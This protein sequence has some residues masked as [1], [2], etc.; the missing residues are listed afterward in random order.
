MG[1]WTWIAASRRGTSHEKTG[2]RCQDAR[3]CSL[4]GENADVLFAVASDGAGSA[5]HGGQ[6]ASLTCRVLTTHARAHFRTTSSL[7]SDEDIATWVDAVKDNIWAAATQ[8]GLQPRDFAAT[9]VCVIS[10]GNDTVTV[11]VG[12]G[13]AVMKISGHGNWIAASWPN[14]GEYASTTF[15]VT[16]D[17]ELKLR[18]TRLTAE[19]VACAVF[20]DGIERLALDFRN[21]VPFEPFFNAV[22]NPVVASENRGRDAGLSEKLRDFLNSDAV[23]AR[24]DDDKT[25]IIAVN[26]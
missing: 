11:H 10:N 5:S 26:K 24:T 7:P 22:V 23:N 25:L 19:V 21:N 14:H 6:G 8:R 4:L 13:C 12:D 20:T 17:K 9:L 2:L 1:Q 18:F 3:S 15:F 16:D